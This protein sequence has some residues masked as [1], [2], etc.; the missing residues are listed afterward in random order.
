MKNKS[1]DERMKEHDKKYKNYLESNKKLGRGVK[2][3][4]IFRTPRADG[5]AYYEIVGLNIPEKFSERP[6]K[7]NIKPALGLS[8]D[9]YRDFVLKEGGWFLWTTIQPLVEFEDDYSEV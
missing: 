6:K 2:V 8:L 7:I 4:K 9:E 1:I 5:W 3:G